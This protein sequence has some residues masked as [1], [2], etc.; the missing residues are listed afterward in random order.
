MKFHANNCQY[1]IINCIYCNKEIQAYY[2][3]T[4]EKTECTQLIQCPKCKTKM[5]RGSYFSKHYNKNNDNIEC[6]K[7]Q[8]KNMEL[9]NEIQKKENNKLKNKIF[10][11]KD[12][13]N[14]NKNELNNI[15]GKLSKRND[16]IKNIYNNFILTENEK[17]YNNYLMTPQRKTNKNINL[18]TPK[19]QSNNYY[20]NSSLNFY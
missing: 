1:R 8:M 12:E 17:E 16:A 9:E 5:T 2:F 3:N 14:R 10:L 4:H 20:F 15:K 7:A 6:L 19:D 11:L 18:L 13:N